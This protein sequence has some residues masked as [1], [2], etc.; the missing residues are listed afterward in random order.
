MR[1]PDGRAIYE[2][3]AY[4]A[5]NPSRLDH[6]GSD[7][8]GKWLETDPE[9][10]GYRNKAGE[11]RWVSPPGSMAIAVDSGKVTGINKT[12]G[13]LVLTMDAYPGYLQRHKHLDTSAGSF[14]VDKGYTVVKGQDLARIGKTGTDTPHAHFEV[15]KIVEGIYPAVDPLP[16]FR[17]QPI[18]EVLPTTTVT[19]SNGGELWLILIALYMLS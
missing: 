17:N 14:L 12:T 19:T 9:W 18:F 13:V 7:V 1:T 5:R 6:H 2:T 10:E 11:R 16:V 4:R 3:S 15:R 8:N